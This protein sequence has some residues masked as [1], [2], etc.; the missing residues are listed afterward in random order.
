MVHTREQKS[1]ELIQKCI[2]SVNSV[3]G[4]T[5]L[6]N[7]LSFSLYA[8]LSICYMVVTSDEWIKSE[9]EVSA[10][11]CI[12]IEH[13]RSSSIRIIFVNYQTSKL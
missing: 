6:W 2:E 8:V 10:D 9:I 4:D 1:A 7:N 13:W 5:N 12:A 3:L 11:W